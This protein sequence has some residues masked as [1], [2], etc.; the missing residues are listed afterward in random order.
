ML[1]AKVRRLALFVRFLLVQ[2]LPRAVRSVLAQAQTALSRALPK[3]R[4]GWNVSKAVCM[5]LMVGAALSLP[6]FASESGGSGSGS[7]GELSSII[8]A[9]DT[10]VTMVSKAWDAMTANPLLRVYVA[11]GLLS[12]GIGF[13]GYLAWAA[14]RR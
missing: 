11:A 3:V 6:A 5:R 9:T 4:V 8:S 10:V 7:G 13:F 1:Q 2:A 14:K 12:T